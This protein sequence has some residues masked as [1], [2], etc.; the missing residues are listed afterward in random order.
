MIAIPQM[1]DPLGRH[2]KQPNRDSI[3]ID[4]TH[5][6]MGQ[7]T[8][9][10]LMTYSSTIPSGVYPGK[11]WKAT[12]DDGSHRMGRKGGYPDFM[13]C[14]AKRYRVGE[15]ILADTVMAPAEFIQ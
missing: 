15:T 3:L 2:W 4:E 8:F 14:T 9:D 11:M 6:V 7:R 10:E 12:L 5:A 13:A 1:T